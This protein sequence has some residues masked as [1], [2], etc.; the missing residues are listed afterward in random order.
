MLPS[1]KF[2]P[3]S[4]VFKTLEYVGSGGLSY[5]YVIISRELKL[6]IEKK[7]L[8]GFKFSPVMK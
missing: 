7:G 3:S 8:K 6:E 2:Y 1:L 4:H 5:R